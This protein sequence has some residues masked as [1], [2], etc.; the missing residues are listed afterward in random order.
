MDCIQDWQHYK[1]KCK[2]GSGSNVSINNRNYLVSGS[3]II[4]DLGVDVEGSQFEPH[5]RQ[6]LESVLVEHCPVSLEQLNKDKDHEQFH[7]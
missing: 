2:T 1:K 6:N 3:S 7:M 4:W 5:C